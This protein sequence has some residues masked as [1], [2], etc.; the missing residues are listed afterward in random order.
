MRKKAY[1][2]V[3]W[4]LLVLFA[5]TLLGD[6]DVVITQVT[7]PT[8]LPLSQPVVGTLTTA[9]T[10]QTEP[11][12]VPN[13]PALPMISV[14][15][16]WAI[17]PPFDIDFELLTAFRTSNGFFSQDGFQLRIQQNLLPLSAIGTLF[18]LNGATPTLLKFGADIEKVLSGDVNLSAIGN[19]DFHFGHTVDHFGIGV[20]VKDDLDS[21]LFLPAWFAQTLAGK[22]PPANHAEDFSG[23]VIDVHLSAGVFAALKFDYFQVPGEIGM[24]TPVLTSHFNTGSNLVSNGTTY[25]GTATVTGQL[26][27]SADLGALDLFTLPHALLTSGGW[28]ADLSILIGKEKTLAG[29]SVSNIPITDA[30]LN[31]IAPWSLNYQASSGSATP[32]LTTTEALIWTPAEHTYRIKTTFAGFINVPMAEVGFFQLHGKWRPLSGTD[33]G[34]MLHF[35]ITDGFSLMGDFTYNTTGF[36]YYSVGLGFYG[37]KTRTNVDIG[38]GSR[39]FFDYATLTSPRISVSSSANY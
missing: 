21:R 2:L 8:T 12:P 30:K 33:I 37:S 31:F 29:F 20:F 28:K 23:S 18:S 22:I 6:P 15:P 3:L 38:I 39:L 32:T 1:Y 9:P 7:I 13:E 10:F 34:G 24:Y 35:F 36:Y 27:S 16:E 19:T 14:E 17:F 4:M 5:T 26:Y 25:A 11:V